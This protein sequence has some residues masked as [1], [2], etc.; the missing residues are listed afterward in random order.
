MKKLNEFKRR[1]IMF[2]LSMMRQGKR[3][4]YLKKKQVFCKFGENCKYGSKSI[5]SE[6][7]L[8][9][10]HNNVRIA[11]N[12]TFCTHDIISGMLQNCPQY[13]SDAEKFRFAMG[14]IEIFDNCMIGANTTLLYNIK[15]G[16]N[17]VVGAGS[18][19]TKDVPPGTI[20]A[21]NPAK[22]IGSFD[23]LAKKR[24]N[25]PAKATNKDSL[26]KII[27]DYWGETL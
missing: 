27:Y 22:V 16:P 17:A 19:V 21:G 5:P 1:W 26:E 11:A 15:I 18:V 12:V 23:E 7:Y 10:I 25:A 6:P 2:R 3:A 14:T 24:A 20:V 13:A 9:K 8:V 4:S